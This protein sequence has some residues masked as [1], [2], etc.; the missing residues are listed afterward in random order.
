MS[1]ANEN[2]QNQEPSERNESSDNNHSVTKISVNTMDSIK[3]ISLEEMTTPKKLCPTK[4]EGEGNISMQ[5][6]LR[7]HFLPQ[8]VMETVE[9]FQ[10]L[11]NFWLVMSKQMWKLH[12]KGNKHPSVSASR[13]SRYNSYFAYC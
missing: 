11:P 8:Y 10:G 12:L 2:Q 9:L 1:S 4:E 6:I 7:V 5:Y 13:M 3:G